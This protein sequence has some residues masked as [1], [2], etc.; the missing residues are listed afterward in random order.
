MNLDLLP[1]LTSYNDVNRFNRNSIMRTLRDAG[2]P[3]DT[4]TEDELRLAY[5][6]LVARGFLADQGWTNL[7]EWSDRDLLGAY[8]AKVEAARPGMASLVEKARD[9][10]RRTKV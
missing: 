9:P 7:E 10:K 5:G 2:H 6:L 1:L 8:A 3:I 4:M